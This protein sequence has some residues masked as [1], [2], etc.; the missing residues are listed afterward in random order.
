MSRYFR[1]MVM[2]FRT[3]TPGELRKLFMN[4]FTVYWWIS[5][6]LILIALAMVTIAPDLKAK[7]Y[8]FAA[9]LPVG[10]ILFFIIEMKDE[11]RENRLRVTPEEQKAYD[12]QPEFAIHDDTRDQVF[13]PNNVI[14][15][16]RSRACAPQHDPAF[17]ERK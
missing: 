14:R 16:D 13:G 4:T 9:L 12:E 10:K 7:L 11:E 5:L 15:L 17:F 1:F 2:E 3:I 8:L 6:P